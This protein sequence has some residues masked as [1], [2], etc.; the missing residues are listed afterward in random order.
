LYVGPGLHGISKPGKMDGGRILGVEPASC[1]PSVKTAG[2]H[3][4]SSSVPNS[5]P[6]LVRVKSFDNGREI[7]EYDSPGQLNFDIQDESSASHPHFLPEFHDGLANSAR[8]IPPEVAA[9]INLKTQERIESMQFCQVN[10]NGRFMEFNECKLK[11]AIDW[12]V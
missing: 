3:G 5:L 2:I 8:R 9:N 12:N 11:S 6:S 10:S 4:V 7:T 1:T